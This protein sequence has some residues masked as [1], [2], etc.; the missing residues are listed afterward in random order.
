MSCIRFSTP[1]QM[2]QLREVAP[3]TLTREQAASL[4]P[5][6][7][8]TDSKIRRLRL[9]ARDSNPKIRESVAS[10]Y[11]A[12]ADVLAALARDADEGVRACLARNEHAPVDILRGLWDDES[13]SVRGWVAIN[14]RTP[15]DVLSALELDSSERVRALLRWRPG[16]KRM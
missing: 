14:A 16:V 4:H 8:V 3:S 13:E 15:S 2:K 11:N 5:A 7:A 12:P 6:P 10:S 1:A 9:L